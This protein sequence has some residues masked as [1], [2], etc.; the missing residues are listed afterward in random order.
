MA[1]LA[2]ARRCALRLVSTCRRRMGR[3]RD[4]AR[5]DERVTAL[6]RPDRA[7]A[8]RLAVGTIAAQA[9]L[10]A[11]VD[12]RVRRRSSLE[13]RV[14]DALCVALYEI[15]Y[16]STPTAVSVSQGVELVRSVAPRAAGLANAVLRWASQELRQDIERA[17]E[18]SAQMAATPKD[19]A[20]V[21]GMPDWLVERIIEDRGIAFATKLC[22]ANLEPAPLYLSLNSTRLTPEEAAACFERWG[23]S[24]EGTPG[25]PGSYEV[26]D[27]A[28]LVS[29]G[30]L[31]EAYIVVSDLSAQ[32]ICRIAGQAD[33]YTLLEIG[34]GRATKTLLFCTAA[35]A[36]RPARVVGVD[37][38]GYK[39]EVARRRLDQA[40]LTDTAT[41]VTFDATELGAMELP[42]PLAAHFDVVFVDAPCSG[43]G[44]MRRH[45][46]T[47]SRLTP[48]EVHELAQLQRRLLRAAATRVALGGVLVYSTCSVLRDEDEA[49]VKAFLESAEGSRFTLER[50]SEAPC[51]THNH[52]LRGHVCAHE[53]NDGFY[54]GCPGMGEP[55][56]HFCVRLVSAR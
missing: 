29:S 25:M 4:I 12:Q 18:R 6:N 5:T 30:L 36:V 1:R 52:E 3:I 24:A 14:R 50:V 26:S 10:D 8:M 2:P 37:A 31:E 19:L 21:S 33:P 11:L 35:G 38:I 47:A 48:E 42:D 34:Q 16:L 51:C 49:V 44:T 39:T 46:E 20:L 22:A 45:P 9:Q 23:L 27:G 7:L 28:S 32:T 54:L 15:C 56:G 17:R 55:D 40:G 41:C 13:P 53:T 43:T